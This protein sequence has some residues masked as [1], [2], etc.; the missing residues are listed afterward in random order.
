MSF[1]IRVSV[2]VLWFV[3]P[4]V[5]A[6]IYGGSA[7]EAT[8][9]IPALIMLW[10]LWRS[11][12]DLVLGA[13]GLFDVMYWSNLFVRIPL[14]TWAASIVSDIAA[15]ILGARAFKAGLMDTWWEFGIGWLGAIAIYNGV[16]WTIKIACDI[17]AFPVRQIIAIFDRTDLKYKTSDIN[18]LYWLSRVYHE[19]RGEATDKLIKFVS[20]AIGSVLGVIPFFWLW[21]LMTNGVATAWCFG[22]Y[23][24][25]A[26]WLCVHLA[27]D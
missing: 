17:I 20:Y 23:Y 12:V 18:S 11:I 9:V 22:I 27:D 2:N 13:L 25:F 10:P 19:T 6:W 3:I 7:L 1:A 5:A 4:Y 14:E 8:I 24:F 21:Y 16:V 26:L 15:F